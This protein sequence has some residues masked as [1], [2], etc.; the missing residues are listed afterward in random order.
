MREQGDHIDVIND[1]LKAATTAY[2]ASEFLQSL[3]RQYRERGSLSKKQLEGLQAKT[4]RLTTISPGKRA[5]LQAIIL[6]KH[7][8]HRSDPP[9]PT[10]MFTKNEAAGKM[11]TALLEKFPQH[12]RVLFLQ[13]KYHNNETLSPTE[14]TELERFAKLLL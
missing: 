1:I 3:H 7:T 6:K 5:T 14:I 11:I 9:A 2:P 4:A 13:T 10:P 12:K 8:R